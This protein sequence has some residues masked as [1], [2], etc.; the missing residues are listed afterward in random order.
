MARMTISSPESKTT[1][2]VEQTCAG[3]EAE[4]EFPAGRL[5]IGQ[6]LDPDGPLRGLDSILCGHSV[7]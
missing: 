5:V 3:V 4:T 2:T 6:W 7:L 1:T